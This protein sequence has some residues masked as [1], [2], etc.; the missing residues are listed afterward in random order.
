MVKPLQVVAFTQ[1]ENVPSARFRVRQY[2]SKLLSLG[3]AMRE[4][5]ARF[6]SYP[7]GSGLA[8]LPWFLSALCER[9][10]AAFGGGAADVVLF[11][12]EMVSTLYL[13]ERFCRA[14]AVLDVDDAIWLTQRWHSVDKLARRCRMVLCGNAYLAEHFQPF[15]ETRIVPTGVDTE[16]WRPGE[17]RHLGEEDKAPVI[18]WSGS[19]GGLPYL[20]ELEPALVRVLAAV[21]RA[22]LR[23][24]CN[25]PPRLSLVP[26]ER[27]EFVQWSP[28]A[29]VA[30]VQ[31][32]DVGLMPMP[33]TPWT[34]GKCS[35]KMLTYMACGVPAVA[36][37]WGMNAE[38]IAGGGAL[39]AVSA[40]DWVDT[41]V[42]LLSDCETARTLG[43][44]GRAQVEARY[45]LTVL[46]PRIA[47]A[48]KD[49][50][51]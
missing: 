44:E 8:R 29:E 28:D 12:R 1:G 5:P 33:D 16:L 36:S 43:A 34:R 45:S 15:A 31:S 9:S 6:G 51:R 37:P 10:L 2:R 38:V 24:V 13:P 27:V 7:Q 47:Q 50:A 26:A 18:L 4:S 25:A 23:I 46:A 40:D 49:S 3:V 21:P 11:Q 42:S 41:L 22:R 35:F 39:G 20:Y 30:A 48:L 14:P 32:A 17:S 19:S